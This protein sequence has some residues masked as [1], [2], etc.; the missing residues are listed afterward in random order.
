LDAAGFEPRTATLV[1]GV[2]RHADAA[3]LVAAFR[4]GTARMAAMLEA[5]AESAMPA[6]LAGLE[7]AAAS[8]R[9]KDGQLAVPIACV[10]AAGIKR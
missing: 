3:S 5:Q 6:I 9:D 7:A 4:G 2:W 1:R 8:W 10:I